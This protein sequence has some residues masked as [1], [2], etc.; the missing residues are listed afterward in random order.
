[1]KL[2]E[3]KGIL[4]SVSAEQKLSQKEGAV[5]TKQVVL[6]EIP[7]RTIDDG[8]GGSKKLNA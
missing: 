5:G 1:M 7:S 8:W 3:F 4:K 6:I 2:P